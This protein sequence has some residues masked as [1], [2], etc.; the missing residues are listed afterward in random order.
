MTDIQLKLNWNC[1]SFV[2]YL[3]YRRLKLNWNCSE[4]T[5]KCFVAW[6][7]LC[8]AVGA[9]AHLEKVNLANTYI[10]NLTS[11][12]MYMYCTVLENIVNKPW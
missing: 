2:K 1:K 8:Q 4:T 6:V 9:N 7:P 5:L 11:F 12:F 3:Y 10:I